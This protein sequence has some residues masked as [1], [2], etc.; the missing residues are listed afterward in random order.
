MLPVLVFGLASCTTASPE[1][2]KASSQLAAVKEYLKSEG[3]DPTV[4]ESAGAGLEGAPSEPV[5]P[6]LDGYPAYSDV[7]VMEAKLVGAMRL[8][9]CSVPARDIDGVMFVECSDPTGGLVRMSVFADGS[10]NV[11]SLIDGGWVVDGGPTWSV[12]VNSDQPTLA[13]ALAALR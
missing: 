7:T 13:A 5:V 8:S 4:A 11:D 12:S 3:V 2:V 6:P 10:S 9:G 1:D